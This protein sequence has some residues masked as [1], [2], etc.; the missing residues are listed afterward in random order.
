MLEKSE[1]GKCQD[2]FYEISV[3]ATNLQ[4]GRDIVDML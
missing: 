4:L 3:I 1:S 2:K